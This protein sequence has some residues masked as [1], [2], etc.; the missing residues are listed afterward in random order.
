MTDQ[1]WKFTKINEEICDKNWGVKKMKHLAITS[2]P[3]CIIIVEIVC[4]VFDVIKSEPTGSF[5]TGCLASF[6]FLPCS[7]TL[8]NP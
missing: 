1:C 5:K 6:S 7:C 4:H 8:W 3:K 2:N